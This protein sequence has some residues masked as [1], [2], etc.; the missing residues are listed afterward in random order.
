MDV[1]DNLH[2]PQ[3]LHGIAEDVAADGLRDILHELRTVA[4]YPL[5]FLCG[6]NALIGNGLTDIVNNG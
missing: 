2:V 1:S 5:P 3:R 6:T 4:L